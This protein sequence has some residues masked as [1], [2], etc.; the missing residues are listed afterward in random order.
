MGSDTQTCGAC[1]QGG[2]AYACGSGNY[3]TGTQCTGTS[4]TD[5]QKCAPC[6]GG[7]AAYNCGQHYRRTGSTC[8]GVGNRDT[9]SC[10]GCVSSC[11]SGYNLVNQCSGTGT[12]DAS[13]NWGGLNSGECCWWATWMADRRC[14]RCKGG[15]SH[16]WGC[17]GVG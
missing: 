12:G 5:T 14:S 7:G 15:N 6:H 16:S 17:M 10:T 13:C 2:S 4:F 3:R 9:Q 1:Q 8:S 11:Q